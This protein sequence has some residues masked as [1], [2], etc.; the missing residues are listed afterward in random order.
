MIGDKELELLDAAIAG[1]RTGKLAWAKSVVEPPTLVAAMKDDL[2]L[3][4]VQ[5]GVHQVALELRRGDIPVTR[6]STEDDTTDLKAG[7]KLIDL[8][9]LAMGQLIDRDEEIAKAI[10]YMKP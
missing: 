10:G 7:G 5:T 3:S 8:W 9:E 1:T 6:V 2:S 4:L